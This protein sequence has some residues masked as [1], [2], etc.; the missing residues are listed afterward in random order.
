MNNDDRFTDEEIEEILA[1]PQFIADLDALRGE[2]QGGSAT[3]P[4]NPKVVS[5]ADIRKRECEE[6]AK[7]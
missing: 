6:R 2:V 5:F 4:A 3:P 7:T 1:D